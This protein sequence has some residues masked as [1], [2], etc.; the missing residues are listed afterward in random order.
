ML[1]RL[2]QRGGDL[3]Q[4]SLPRNWDQAL[5]TKVKVGGGSGGGMTTSNYSQKV[6][7]EASVTSQ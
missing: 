4:E 3:P 1:Y 5:Q 6:S 7:C 2:L